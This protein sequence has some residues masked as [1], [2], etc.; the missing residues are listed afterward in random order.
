M[1][2]FI[3]SFVVSC[4]DLD[5]MVLAR[6]AFASL[7]NI[8]I[9]YLLPL[10]DIIGNLPVWSG[11]SLPSNSIVLNGVNLF[12]QT[13]LEGGSVVMT[14]SFSGIEGGGFSFVE[15]RFCRIWRKCPLIIVSDFGRCFFN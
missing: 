10:L 7:T 5:F 15:R 13:G 4:S 1:C 2:S 3:I 8:T 6:I 12:A 9:T 11:K 14:V